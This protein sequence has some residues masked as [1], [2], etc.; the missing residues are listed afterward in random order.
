VTDSPSVLGWQMYNY[1]Y[2]YPSL[3]IY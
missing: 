2:H 1:I 3:K